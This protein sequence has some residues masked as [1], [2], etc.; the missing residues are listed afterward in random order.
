MLFARGS[1]VNR[2]RRERVVSRVCQTFAEAMAQ[3]IE[4]A[5]LDAPAQGEGA[6]FES[7]FP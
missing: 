1:S 7:A 2:E 4:V 3:R 5:H 6:R